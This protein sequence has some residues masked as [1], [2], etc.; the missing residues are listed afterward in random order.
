MSTFDINLYTTPLWSFRTV[1]SLTML[2]ISLSKRRNVTYSEHKW[3]LSWNAWAARTIFGAQ[4]FQQD[5]TA[6]IKLVGKQNIYWFPK[7]AIFNWTNPGIS[8]QNMAFRNVKQLHSFI[9]IW[10]RYSQLV[11]LFRIILMSKIKEIHHW[12]TFSQMGKVVSAFF[13]L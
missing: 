3:K 1:P 8:G 12:C 4:H 7:Y 13:N 10:E 5:F 11:L 9:G 2:I 6:A